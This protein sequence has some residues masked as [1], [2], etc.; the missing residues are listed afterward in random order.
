ML[1]KFRQRIKKVLVKHG[2]LE[3]GRATESLALS[4]SEDASSYAD[5]LIEKGFCGEFAYLGAMAQETNLPPVDVDKVAF[6]EAALAVINP[7][8]AQY[9]CVL[10]VS[11][12]GGVLTLAVGN[13]FDILKL[14]DL[15][16][17]TDCD[18]RPVL[19]TEGAIKRNIGRAYQGVA[20]TGTTTVTSTDLATKIGAVAADQDDGDDIE[21][22]KEAQEVIDVS[23][24]VEGAKDAPI[25]KTV[26]MIVVNALKQKASDIHIEPFEKYVRVRI[27]I[28]GVLREAPA[29]PPQ[30]HNGV[31]SRIKILSN[32]DIAERRVPQDGKFQV[33]FEGR[34]IDFRVSIMPTIYG[35]KAE[36]RVLDSSS[37]NVTLN[38]LGLSPSSEQ[39]FRRAI[40][41]SYGWVLVTGPT[42]SGKTTTLYAALREILNLEENTVTVEEP[43]EY[44]LERINQV[45]VNVKRGLT[46]ASA[47]RSILRQDPDVIMIGEVRDF[48]T[49]DIAVK[50]SITGHLVLSTL[51]TND[52][53]SA[54]TRLVDMG[55]D[56][57]MVAS[58]VI[59]VGAQRLMRRL[60]EKCK[61]PLDTVPPK[62]RLLQMGFAKEEIARAKFCKPVGCSSCGGGYKGRFCV[63]EA[64]EVTRDVQ[65]MIIEGKAAT[66]IKAHALGTGMATLRRSAC[67][68]V[69]EGNTSIDEMLRNTMGD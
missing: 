25:V 61:A 38:Q 65:R 28:D 18:L 42:G 33:R 46:F 29:P 32:L 11:K 10:P 17:L 31:I 44:Q 19:G 57:F 15:R 36:L 68:A 50:A 9:Y 47:L 56:A 60:C 20:R 6:D 13:P 53:A 8:L 35:E 5:W 34:Q 40:G 26:N 43:V 22:K 66:D 3:E 48:E 39:A 7:E 24:E 14:D 52:A 69:L 23:K 30:M 55:V 4:E 41:A 58:S 21:L 54:I 45:P 16:T 12:I 2:V 64:L 62:D 27:R 51:H 63:M 49:A 1:D 37:L 67:Q 59:M